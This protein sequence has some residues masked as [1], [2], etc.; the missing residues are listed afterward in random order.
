VVFGVPVDD[1]AA[2]GV[3]AAE[4]PLGPDGLAGS[5]LVAVEAARIMA[6]VG[7]SDFRAAK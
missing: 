7:V 4:V 5:G 1:G 3:A 6:D 2:A